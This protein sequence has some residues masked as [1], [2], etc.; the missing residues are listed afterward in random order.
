MNCKTLGVALLIGLWVWDE[1]SFNKYHRNYEHITQVMQHQVLNDE[2]QTQP[3]VPAPLGPALRSSFGNDFKYVVVSTKTT[4]HIISRGEKQFTKPGNF[5]EADAPELLTLNMIEGSR[6][7]LKDPS[8][9]LLSA[10]LAK[11]IFG[12]TFLCING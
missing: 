8:S 1:I 6:E 12:T 10:G 3:D 7:G 11:A 2:V 4:N 9:I 5:M